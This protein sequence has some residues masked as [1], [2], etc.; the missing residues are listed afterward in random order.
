ML[1]ELTVTHEETAWIG[2]SDALFQLKTRINKLAHSDLPIHIVGEPGSG[3]QLAAYQIYRTP[4]YKKGKFVSFCCKEFSERNIEKQMKGLISQAK[5][6]TLYLKNVC[7]LTPLQFND[8]KHY[9]LTDVAQ[10]DDVQ[11]ITSTTAQNQLNAHLASDPDELLNWLQYHCLELSMPTL[12]Q[13]CDDIAYLIDYYKTTNDKIAALN[14]DATAM[15]VLKNYAWPNNV[16]QLKRCLEKLT[17]SVDDREINADIL[18]RNFPSMNHNGEISNAP[19]ITSNNSHSQPTISLSSDDTYTVEQPVDSMY[20]HEHYLQIDINKT[21]TPSNRVHPALG[22]ALS[23]IEAYYTHPLSLSE[24]ASHACVSPSHLSY[25]FKR[26]VGQSFKQ[27]LLKHRIRAA[28]NLFRNDPYSQVTEVCDDV[29]FSD[30]SFF[31]RK[32]KAVVGVSPG[33]YRD[34]R[35]KH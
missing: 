17:F 29:G 25:L 18:L 33:V 10:K 34:Q 21:L 9:W 11:L 24:V 3:K 2:S 15:T 5:R 23:Y 26:Y 6:G 8:I 13:R 30:L 19:G 22:K 28:M 31:V 16:K 4:S 7:H 32:F 14:F 12:A 1:T 35:A 27:T 20:S